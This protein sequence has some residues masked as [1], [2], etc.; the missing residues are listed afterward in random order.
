M[1]RVHDFFHAQAVFADDRL[2]SLA[3][4]IEVLV[5]DQGKKPQDL[6]RP[7]VILK[8]RQSLCAQS[9]IFEGIGHGCIPRLP[10]Y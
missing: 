3:L 6:H 5:A 7:E 1:I 8:H 2:R 9:I 4:V 10:G